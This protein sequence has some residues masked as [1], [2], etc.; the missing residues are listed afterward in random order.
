M[1]QVNGRKSLIS[2]N[3]SIPNGSIFIDGSGNLSTKDNNG[4]IQVV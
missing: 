1:V 4:V 3:I 2:V